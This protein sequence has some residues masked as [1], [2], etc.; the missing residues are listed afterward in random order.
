MTQA[1]F[2]HEPTNVSDVPKIETVLGETIYGKLTDFPHTFTFFISEET[3]FSARVSMDSTEPVHDVSFILVKQEKRG[4]SEVGRLTGKNTAWTK[5]YD[6]WR[7]VAFMEGE[8]FTTTLE[9]GIYKFEISS[10]ENNRGYRL[11]LGEG[12]S[13]TFKEMS[14]VRR[15]FD[16]HS[17]SILLSPFVLMPLTI[18][19]FF[20][21]RRFRRSLKNNYA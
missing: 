11:L 5:H 7:A 13:Q 18:G 19:L 9:Q 6:L 4:V 14:L 15:V 3:P 10:P 20:I 21:A 12:D 2:L 16:V 1:A 8:V 17:L